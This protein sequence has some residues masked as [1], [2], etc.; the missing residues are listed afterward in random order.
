MISGKAGSNLPT[1]Q[2]MM[3]PTAG[4]E[5]V[6]TEH[7]GLYDH[8][9]YPFVFD[10]MFRVKGS[11]CGFGYIDLAKSAQEYIDFITK[12]PLLTEDREAWNKKLD[13]IKTKYGKETED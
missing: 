3:P 9:L 10:S 4:P 5:P 2:P 7:Y 1:T 6:Q 11:P 13:E 12:A 8:G